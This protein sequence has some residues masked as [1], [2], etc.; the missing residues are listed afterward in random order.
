MAVTDE[1]VLGSPMHRCVPLSRVVS[2]LALAL[3]SVFGPERT[4]RRAQSIMVAEMHS[5]MNEAFICKGCGDECT[6]FGTERTI[7]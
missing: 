4:R 3:A 7:A 6:G 1:M 2:L 5:E